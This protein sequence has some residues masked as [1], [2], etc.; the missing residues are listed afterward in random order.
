M[1]IV[2]TVDK[3]WGIGKGGS[4]LVLIPKE[5]SLIMEETKNKVVIFG[6]KTFEK[7]NFGNALYGRTNIVF[8]KNKACNFKNVI[9]VSS[10]EE[11]LAYL[12]AENIKDE[13]IFIIGGKSMYELFFKY[14]S[15]IHI[16]M[17]DFEYEA[18]EFFVDLDKHKDWQLL[19]E[20]EEETY[21][22]LSYKFK[23]YQN[24]RK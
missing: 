4:S 19:L 6:R 1:N 8:S 9:K 24:T 3:S 7:F 15:F 23:L 18:D 2:A 5:K 12:Q 22:D 11:C 10:L 16:T 14:A 21:F 13:D 20:T 17:I